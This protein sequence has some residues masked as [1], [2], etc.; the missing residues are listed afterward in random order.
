MLLNTR[1]KRTGTSLIPHKLGPLGFPV[2]QRH[3][4][5]LRRSREQLGAAA[6]RLFT[7]GWPQAKGMCSNV[8]KGAGFY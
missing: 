5:D 7:C 3:A 6:T 4:K 2:S 1:G 8:I